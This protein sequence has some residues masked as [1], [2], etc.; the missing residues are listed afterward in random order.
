MVGDQSQQLRGSADRL[1]VPSSKVLAECA[2]NGTVMGHVVGGRGSDGGGAVVGLESGEQL[3][4]GVFRGRSYSAAGHNERRRKPSASCL[5]TAE[6]RQR[7]RSSFANKKV[8]RVAEPPTQ[9]LRAGLY[10][11]EHA[12]AGSIKAKKTEQAPECPNR[13]RQAL[14]TPECAVAVANN[15]AVC[16]D[17]NVNSQEESVYTLEDG[18]YTEFIVVL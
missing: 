2:G 15:E 17:L 11:C 6:S 5:A 14:T 7:R 1:Q 16:N 10:S 18:L 4:V 9:A 8:V 12:T 13:S 3:D